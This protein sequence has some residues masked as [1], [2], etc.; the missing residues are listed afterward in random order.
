[1]TLRDLIKKNFNI[2]KDAHIGMFAASNCYGLRMSNEG[3][4]KGLL[5]VG[6]NHIDDEV[7][8]AVLTKEYLEEL[9]IYRPMISINQNRNNKRLII[10]SVLKD[11]INLDSFK[12][13]GII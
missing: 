11:K 10:T 2:S 12:Y 5:F 1:M 13:V 3:S 7:Y 6:F 4:N 9:T 8:S